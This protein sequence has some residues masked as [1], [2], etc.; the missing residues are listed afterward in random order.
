MLKLYVKVSEKKMLM[1][2]QN[3]QKKKQKVTLYKLQN[4]VPRSVII[5][6]PEILR[7]LQE[8]N[9]WSCFFLKK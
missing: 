2:H 8:K 1:K 5:A 7:K 4:Q 9:L 3:D 6:A